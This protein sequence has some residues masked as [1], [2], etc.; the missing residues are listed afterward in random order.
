MDSGILKGLAI[1]VGVS[2]TVLASA[3]MLSNNKSSTDV[4]SS[5]SSARPVKV[6]SAEPHC[7]NEQVVVNKQ[8]ADHTTEGTLIG[9]AL[10]GLAGNQFGKGSGNAAATAAGAVA[11]AMIGRNQGKP[12]TTQEVQT[13]RRCR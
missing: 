12:S 5:S 6:A 1:G 9:G 7:W 3:Y 11:G 13:V 2:A 8:G 4:A 10:G